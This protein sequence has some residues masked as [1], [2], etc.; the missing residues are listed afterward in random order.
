MK[1]FI[2]TVIVI[3]RILELLEKF[4]I[5]FRVYLLLLFSYIWNFGIIVGIICVF[6][7]VCYLF[8]VRREWFLF[9]DSF[10][11]WCRVFISRRLLEFSW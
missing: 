9:V 11:I 4:E 1:E 10:F 7:E 5:I 2:F 3:V 8:I 6:V